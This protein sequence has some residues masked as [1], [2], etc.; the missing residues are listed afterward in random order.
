MVL[1]RIREFSVTIPVG[2]YWVLGL[3]LL[4]LFSSLDI[5]AQQN[6]RAKKFGESLKKFEKRTTERPETR[7]V[8]T[9][10]NEIRIGT[11]LVVSDLLVT[12]QKGN[13]VVG[14]EKGDFILE[15]D[16]V[17]QSIDLFSPAGTN[18]LPKSIVIILDNNSNAK[19]FRDSVA[20][21]RS[22][23]DWLG[24]NDRLAIVADNIRLLSDFTSDKKLLHRSLDKLQFRKGN[25]WWE[26]SSLLAV[27][28]ELF[29]PE[30]RRPI[31]LLQTEGAEVLML[32]PIWEGQK[33]FCGRGLK[34]LCE[35]PY[36]LADVLSAVEQSRATVYGII[37]RARIVGLPRDEQIKR[38]RDLLDMFSTEYHG[39]TD[40]KEL[41][42]FRRKWE[43]LTLLETEAMQKSIIDV[44]K[45]SGGF[46]TFLESA[47]GDYLG[48]YSSIFKTIENRYTIG[49]YSRS[50]KPSEIA[51][52]IGIRIKNRPEYKVVGRTSYTPG[53]K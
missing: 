6:N 24:P 30:D 18:Q 47:D 4:L 9:E 40:E 51:R 42:A 16:G 28:N 53:I 23:I 20:A 14:L 37:P 27:L 25:S 17:H 33:S 10:D 11:E 45:V 41:A 26:L 3:S 34:G 46:T 19:T 8:R 32:R 36:S 50:E 12:D 15:E 22:L 38:T 43:D 13:L 7:T 21:A 5:V 48:L 52:S 49:Y 2:K 1:S 29:K 44:S 39:R 31:V 35:R